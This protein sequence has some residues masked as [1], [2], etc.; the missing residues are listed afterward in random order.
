[1]ALER[2]NSFITMCWAAEDDRQM[3]YRTEGEPKINK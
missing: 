3:L 1:M 2:K